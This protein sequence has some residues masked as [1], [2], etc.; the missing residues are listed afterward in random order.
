MSWLDNLANSIKNSFD[1]IKSANSKTVDGSN[2][3][4]PLVSNSTGFG[5]PPTGTV[6]DY[7]FNE[8]K[9]AHD[10]QLN[11]A[12]SSS[13]PNTNNNIVTPIAS[14]QPYQFGVAPI[15]NVD[16]HIKK[17]KAI[18]ESAQSAQKNNN[19]VPLI[20]NFQSGYGSPA[21]GTVEN[22]ISNQSRGDRSGTGYFSDALFS[23]ATDP[24]G[25]E[26]FLNPDNWPIIGS[27][28]FEKVQRQKQREHREQNPIPENAFI[29]GVLSDDYK[30]K[31]QDIFNGMGY[32]D[33]DYSVGSND[34]GTALAAMYAPEY[35]EKL[36]QDGE[37]P[38]SVFTRGLDKIA[39]ENFDEGPDEQTGTLTM[40]D[41]KGKYMLGS[42]YIKYRD[43][44]FGGR[45][46][47][48]PN[49]V[50]NKLDEMRDFN[51]IPYIEDK[52][53]LQNW[54]GTQIFDD[55]TKLYNQFSN[56]RDR[57]FDA[58]IKY[59]DSELSRRDYE[60][61]MIPYLND[62]YKRLEAMEESDILLP[63]DPRVN[64]ACISLEKI[65]SI[66]LDDGEVFTISSASEP[67]VMENLDGTIDVWWPGT[68]TDGSPIR[69]YGWDD[70]DKNIPTYTW[71]T[72]TP[73]RAQ[74]FFPVPTLD[75]VQ[76]DGNNV[77]LTYNQIRD[78]TEGNNVST[79][80]GFLNMAKR[81]SDDR[82]GLVDMFGSIPSEGFG[83]FS[84]FAPYM[85][86]L[87]L[88]SAPY[89]SPYTAWPMSISNGVSSAQGLDAR[90]YNSDDNTY[91]R[92][93][94]DMT[95]EKYLLNT[96][97]STASPLME[98]IAGNLGG[99]RSLLGSPIHRVLKQK[100]APAIARRAWDTGG[101]GIEEIIANTWEDLQGYGT[102]MWFADPV[103]DE[104]G[105]PMYDDSGHIIRD[106]NTPAEKRIANAISA[107]PENFAAG[108]ALGIPFTALRAAQGD[109]YNNSESIARR[110]LRRFEKEYGIPHYRD[111]KIGNEEVVITPND[112]GTYGT[113]R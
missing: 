80:Y 91:T 94:D 55:V 6:S 45:D 111:P 43:A 42:Q 40:D 9:K 82:K 27:T 54:R 57:S 113:R 85:S 16:N 110:E 51:F 89:F 93:S 112:I 52:D 68:D 29:N 60:N 72:T 46:Y 81:S 18:S 12:S 105:D 84:D 101:E 87:L 3:L 90:V 48:D 56:L 59:G 86:D 20:G 106:P 44:G 33:K 99:S 66:P 97:L 88:G 28:P 8:A 79:D 100:G 73:D 5:M 38:I 65:W 39:N 31:Y 107:M 62:V 10:N 7:M 95:G 30:K 61:E 35:R 108:T 64:D 1:S 103:L 26:S 74:G 4:R 102:S 104:N 14:Y 71:A 23:A 49:K 13:K 24:F 21:I 25:E 19:I 41:L 58:T 98:R 11:N 92:L 50:Y 47:I 75:Y 77:S 67:E 96:M 63:G 36:M 34:V 76:T 17:S 22:H 2:L 109:G 53:Q 70:Y 83:A 78:I 15:G 37:T 32:I 69:Y